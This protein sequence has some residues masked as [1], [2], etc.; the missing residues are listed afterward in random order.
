L[1]PREV[2]RI[3]KQ[4]AA[5]EFDDARGHPVQEAAVVGDEHHAAAILQQQVFQP[6]DGIEV[7]VV[8]RLVQ[9]QHVG[10]AHQRLRQR[11]ALAVAAGQ[12]ADAR[13]RVEMKAVQGLVDPLLPVPAVLGFDPPLEH[14]QV[15]AAVGVVV[16]QRNDLGQTG[17]DRR[18]HRRFG[19][20]VGLLLHESRV[21]ALLPL[22]VAVVR[23]LEAGQDAQQRGLAGAVA[24]DEAHSLRSLQ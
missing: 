21:Q 7:Q 24:S 2:A 19:V 18:E 14:V 9:Q 23:P 11:D 15:A 20:Q 17:L 10:P 3:G 6:L 13:L 4:P 12:G 5:I 8:G 22:H 1:V 16:D